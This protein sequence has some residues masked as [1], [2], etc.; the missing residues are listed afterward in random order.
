MNSDTAF[1][2]EDIVHYVFSNIVSCFSSDDTL[3]VEKIIKI[4]G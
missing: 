3:F 4:F 1:E 2:I